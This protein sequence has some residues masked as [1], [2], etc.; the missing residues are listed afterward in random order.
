MTGILKLAFAMD[1]AMDL[2]IHLQKTATV[3]GVGR[4]QIAI[5]VLSGAPA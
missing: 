1:L 5:Q 2:E 3:K 4:L